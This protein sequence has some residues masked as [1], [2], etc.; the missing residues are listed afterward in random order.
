MQQSAPR[1]QG[2]I[3]SKRRLPKSTQELADVI[4]RERAL[5]LVGQ[6]PD[7]YRDSRGR[8]DGCACL[9][10]PAKLHPMHPLVR[11]IGWHDAQRLVRAF[12]G[13]ILW[14]SKCADLIREWR[15]ANIRRLSA[16]GLKVQ[17]LAEW[18]GLSDRMIRNILAK[19]IAPE[20][21]KPRLMQA[22]C[23]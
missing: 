3:L 1:L 22:V 7:S 13:E 12:G 17:Q 11:M 9:Y 19:E 14:P 20:A 5:F 15:D 8:F 21:S 10:I 4:G 16:D 6:L 23:A 18:F 2:L